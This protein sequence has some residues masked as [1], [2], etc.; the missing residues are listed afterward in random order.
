MS[1]GGLLVV[2]KT[3][4]TDRRRTELGSVDQK[5]WGCGSYNKKLHCIPQDWL[6]ASLL[7][8]VKVSAPKM[9]TQRPFFAN[10]FSAFRARSTPGPFQAKS[11]T[12]TG[13]ITPSAF[14]APAYISTSTTTATSSSNRTIPTKPGADGP[15]STSQT[16]S[17]QP[18]KNSSTSPFGTT[19]LSTSPGTTFYRRPPSPSPSHNLAKSPTGHITPTHMTRGRQRRDSGSSNTSGNFMDAA[20]PEKWYIGG[21]TATGEERFYQLGLVTG[22]EGKRLRSLDRLSL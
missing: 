2:E 10:F 22:S 17:A 21:R 18:I 8:Q 16:T 19:V 11:S 4:N 6:R 15:T 9:P 14:T 20:G 1:S 13:A 12:T 3:S 5:H 7:Q